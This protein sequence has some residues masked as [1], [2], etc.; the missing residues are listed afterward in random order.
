MRPIHPVLAWLFVFGLAWPAPAHKIERSGDVAGTWHLERNHNPRSGEPARVWVALTQAGGHAIPLDQCDCQLVVYDLN[1]PEVG[2]VLTPTLQALSPEVFRGIPGAD[3]AFPRVGEYRLVLTG[4]PKVPGQFAHFQLS[5]TT[6]VAAG[7]RAGR[8]SPSPG[9][10]LTAPAPAGSLDQ[11]Q[12]APSDSSRGAWVI[13]AG[14][15]LTLIALGLGR[16]WQR[17]RGRQSSQPPHPKPQSG[18]DTPDGPG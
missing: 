10:Q 18:R 2:A 17:V 9:E 6:V 8:S 5:Y 14:T 7:S 16:G 3:L 13:A 1:Q 12:P 4:K 15:T 11:A